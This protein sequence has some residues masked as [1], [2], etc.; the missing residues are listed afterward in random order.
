MTREELEAIEER[1]IVVQSENWIKG[2]RDIVKDTMQDKRFNPRNTEELQAISVFIENAPADIYCL[3]AEVRRLIRANDEIMAIAVKI[4]EERDA[5]V[6]D[7]WDVLSEECQVDSLACAFCA[8]ELMCKELREHEGISWQ[9][10]GMQE[11]DT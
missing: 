1:C 2:V 3:L 4:K 11:V 9:W 5:A 8:H 7:L 10:R 6:A